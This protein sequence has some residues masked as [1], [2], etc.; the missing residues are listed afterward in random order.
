MRKLSLRQLEEF[1]LEEFVGSHG[2]CTLCGNH[3]RIDTRGTVS[4]AG[5]PAGRLNFCICPSGR[6]LKQQGAELEAWR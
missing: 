6:A 2:L 4:P 5:R 1:W 3:G